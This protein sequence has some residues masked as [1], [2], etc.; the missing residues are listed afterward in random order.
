MASEAEI[1][2]IV[3]TA[4]T[5]PQL[6]QELRSIISRA[7]DG[8]PQVDINAGLDVVT[9]ARVLAIDLEEAIRDVA[10]TDPTIDVD[11]NLD[12]VRALENLSTE[13]EQVID[14]VD[15]E[16]VSGLTFSEI[17]AR[18][19]AIG[20]LRNEINDVIRVAETN[21]DAVQVDVDVDEERL[22]QF[23]ASL[24]NLEGPS[25][26]LGDSLGTLTR[27]LGLFTA[28]I[29]GLTVAGGSAINVL[30]GVAAAVEQIGPAAAVGASALLTVK[31]AAGTAQL[32]LLGVEDAV[33]KAFDPNVKPDELEK[34]LKGL[35]PEAREF[36]TVLQEM[37]G[38]LTKVQQGVQ[39]RAF[40]GLAETLRTLGTEV[41]PTVTAALN[42]TADSLNAMAQNAATAA[43]QI[44]QQGVLGQ[45]LAGANTALET[46]EKTPA[47]AVR[48]FG[49]LAAAASPAL[50]RI[51]LAV[52]DLSLKIQTRLQRAFESGALEDS[53]DQAVSTLAGLGRTLENFGGGLGNIFGG[54]TQDGAGLFAT[55]EKVSQAFEDITATQGFQDALRTISQTASVLSTTLLTLVGKALA[56]LEPAIVTLGPP[57]QQLASTLGDALGGVFEALGPV[58]EAVAG[59]I[60]KLIPVLTPVITLLGN[61]L[62]AI[63][64]ALIP[65]FDAFGKVFEVIAPFV[66]AV[67]DT[68]SAFLTPILEN[69]GPIVE[70]LLIP[71]VTL[72]QTVFPALTAIIEK[73]Q[74]AFERVGEALGRVTE[75]AGPLLAKFIELAIQIIGQVLPSIQ[76]LI[77]VLVF[78][79]E[80]ALRGVAAVLEGFVIPAMEVLTK[81]LN[82]DVQGAIKQSHEIVSN[83]EIALGR[84]ALA[85][86]DKVVG[87]FTS[88]A[89]AV[90]SKAQEI[91]NGVVQWFTSLINDSVSKFRAL[92]NQI[93][94]AVGDLSARMFQI[95]SNAIQGLI[96]GL[97]SKA[98]SL[99][100]EAQ[101]I[102]NSITSTIEG[103]TGLDIHS[104]SRRLRKTGQ[105]AVAGL[106][107]GMKDKIADL[108]LA[109]LE[110]AEAS[111]SGLG[112]SL[113]NPTAATLG[114]LQGVERPVVT[115]R[116]TNVVN[117]FIGGQ[118][119]K[120]IVNDQFK[121]L[122]NN[123]D[124]AFAQG[125]RI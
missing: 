13:L 112:K 51:A 38:E 16:G 20:N 75:L 114:E 93:V 34:A 96:N 9:A 110:V 89:V 12:R 83:F 65:I 91:R 17:R 42:R 69:L 4:G 84:I 36:V 22:R 118:L 60:G 28:G 74:P 44:S 14:R 70:A 31:L 79:A 62:S 109:S 78:L 3:D 8:A 64:P 2:L 15:R 111:I 77:D 43:V 81:L 108:K 107:K 49:F 50:N 124:R 115:N 105:N 73:L 80:T 45:A 103:I 23:R 88:M 122:V 7:E 27:S 106:I 40:A 87:A 54:L 39:N 56:A 10:A 46:L 85:I 35:A 68:I 19:D 30:A 94:A 52:D 29:A 24:E 1:D 21:L 90:V 123:R 121:A 119:V 53:I 61:L 26:R 102:A 55:L 95:G 57:L 58:L 113:I 100:A 99:I 32:A 66:K 41:A 63:L 98:G 59:A 101:S 86:R 125:I 6:E 33:K 72:Y 67:A 47:R 25:R 104:P 11:A 76:P 97:T 116:G 18:A 82:G 71:F 48:A 92:P 120:Q 117:V 5:L 37:R